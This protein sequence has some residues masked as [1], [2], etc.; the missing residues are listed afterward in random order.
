[1]PGAVSHATSRGNG[2][3]VLYLDD[4]DRE[5]FLNVLGEVCRR[6]HW[7]R[8]AYCL[9]THHDHLVLETLAPNLSRGIRQLTGVYTQ[10]FNR[11]Y[12]RV[13]HVFQGQCKAILMDRDPYLLQLV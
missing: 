2:C 13:G 5:A 1:L 6:M 4:E 9:M 8:D 7:G 12:G 10:Q 3:A 11:H